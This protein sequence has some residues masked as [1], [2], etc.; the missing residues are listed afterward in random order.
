[1]KALVRNCQHGSDIYIS[2]QYDSKGIP[3]YIYK[4]SSTQDGV[5]S[6]SN[7]ICGS[8]W[9]LSL[10]ESSLEISIAE[11]TKFYCKLKSTYLNGRTHHYHDGFSKNKK[12]I[13]LIISHYCRVWQ[14]S[15]PN[16]GLYNIHG[17]LSI[18]NVIFYDSLPVIIDWE[19]FNE[20]I[21][22]IGFDALNLIF[23]QL[24]FDKNKYKSVI[25]NQLSEM[26]LLLKSK[27]CLSP[28]FCQN[29]LRK[30]IDFIST[31]SNIWKNQA[32]KLPIKNF[33]DQ[34]VIKIDSILTKVLNLNN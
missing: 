24:W 31:N 16:D 8:N 12:Y 7:E 34:E 9:Y 20:A 1:M 18:D 22:P 21:A 10:H 30:T 32:D 23:E 17:D 2:M 13:Y 3:N 26:L 11:E 6:L 29:P 25:L 4:S 14:A 28:L 19:H 27:N 5:Q 15:T 33:T